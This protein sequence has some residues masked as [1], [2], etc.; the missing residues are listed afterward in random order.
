MSDRSL[1]PFLTHL[2]IRRSMKPFVL[3]LS[4]FV[5]SAAFAQSITPDVVAS[6][7]N[8]FSNGSVQLSWTL[9]EPTTDTYTGGNTILTQGFHQPNLL[10]TA[11]EEDVPQLMDIALYPNPTA[12]Q[13]TLHVSEHEGALQTRLFDMHGKL[14]LDEQMEQDAL[15]RTF[16]LS[17]LPS[18]HYVLHVRSAADGR[19][20]SFKIQRVSN[21]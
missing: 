15:S 10:I 18:A 20:K 2:Y 12:H 21:P 19:S 8:H 7:G 14:L 17:Q 5:S 11:L 1:K 13:I 4:M 16:D 3:F 9:G 6:S